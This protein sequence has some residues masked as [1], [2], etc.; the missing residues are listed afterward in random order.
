MGDGDY[1]FD[2]RRLRHDDDAEEYI[3]LA[4]M[5]GFSPPDDI[6]ADRITA[7]GTARCASADARRDRLSPLQT[8]FAAI[9]G[10]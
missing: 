5:Q 3:A 6:K 8:N 1:G 2:Q 9:N 7:D 10:T 4:G